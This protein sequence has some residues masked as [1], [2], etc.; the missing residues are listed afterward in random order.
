M[1]STAAV[2]CGIS[3][4]NNAKRRVFENYEDYIWLLQSMNC[5]HYDSLIPITKGD[6]VIITRSLCRRGVQRETPKNTVIVDL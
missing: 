4:S 1:R 5:N 2:F 6:Y 3:G